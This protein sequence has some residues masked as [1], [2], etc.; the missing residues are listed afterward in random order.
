LSPEGFNVITNSPMMKVVVAFLNVFSKGAFTFYLIRIRDD[1]R[2]R[3]K[4]EAKKEIMEMQE[5]HAD[6]FRPSSQLTALVQETLASMGRGRDF[7]AIVEIL[8]RNMITTP[9]D[10]LVLTKAYC[11]EIGL[12]WA[13]VFSFKDKWR[14]GRANKSDAW[15]LQKGPAIISPAA[16]HVALNPQKLDKVLSQRMD[17]SEGQNDKAS[18]TMSPR[19]RQGGNVWSQRMDQNDGALTPRGHQDGNVYGGQWPTAVVSG[20]PSAQVQQLQQQL[21]SMRRQRDEESAELEA[22]IKERMQAMMSDQV[23]RTVMD[24]LNRNLKKQREGDEDGN[25][26]AP[27]SPVSGFTNGY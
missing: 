1:L 12:P 18:D 22:R 21:E 23:N 25:F 3:S 7:E 15:Q 13:F 6:E 20:A 17:R 4:L 27:V 11:I 2:L 9:D 24:V 19:G 14:R 26:D 10:V 8:Y 5:Y 16:P